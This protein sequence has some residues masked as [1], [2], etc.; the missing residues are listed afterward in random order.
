MN[1][2][3]KNI[4]VFLASSICLLFS[5][6]GK[7]QSNLG[8]S[9]LLDT[10]DRN[11]PVSR[12]YEADIRSMDEA[13]KGAKSWMPPEIGAGLFMTPYN[14]KRWKALDS[15]MEEGMG[16][17]MVSIQQM[18]PNPGKLNADRAYMRS[19][20]GAAREERQSSLNNLYAQAK[21]AYYEWLVIEKKK[22]V[23]EENEKVLEFMIK[24]AEIRYKNGLDKISAYYKAKAALSNVQS[25]RIML[26]NESEQR[27][28]AINTLMN[29][30]VKTGFTIDTVIPIKEYDKFILDST[31]FLQNRSDLKAIEREVITNELR[32]KSEQQSLKP[33]F[34]VR[35]EHMFAFGSQPQQFTLM[36]MVKLPMVPWASKMTKSNV[37]SY[38]WKTEA[39]NSERQMILNESSGMANGMRTEIETKKKQVA[40]FEN[41]IVPALRNN[42]RT[43]LLA[44]EQNTEELFMLFDAWE[45]L[46][47]TQVEYLD[48]LQQLLSL[49]V[50]L[51]RVL[52][53]KQ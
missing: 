52:Q 16:S 36:G 27:R 28:I 47:M 39:L 2:L 46:N 20:S 24:N 21:K 6:H 18:I 34:G 50:E 31:F 38:K 44:Y 49:Q 7:G 32:I 22:T 5:T 26:N 17:F 19:M 12:M 43:M 42:Y 41:N 51:E 45:T 23:V 25:M 11:H 48:Q 1:R 14:T 13:A 8:L 15:G 4:Y 10:I 37:E 53:I 30:N 3:S 40:L 29:R 33:Q 9:A 35:F